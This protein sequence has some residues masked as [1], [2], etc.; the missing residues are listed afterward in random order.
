MLRRPPRSTR[1]DTLFPYTTLFRSREKRLA[2]ECRAHATRTTLKQGYSKVFF[3]QPDAL[4]DTR[5]PNPERARRRAEAE[6]LRHDKRLDDRNQIYPTG[7]QP[8]GEEKIFLIR[9]CYA[10]VGHFQS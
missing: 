9:Q 7:Q 2:G 3:Q 1:T 8:A 5:L 4:A 10:P 6:I